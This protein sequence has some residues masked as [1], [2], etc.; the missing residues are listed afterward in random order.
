MLSP[1]LFALLTSSALISDV[2]AAPSKARAWTSWTKNAGPSAVYLTTNLQQN[3]VIALPVAE[4][5]TLSAGTVTS[6]GGAG[7]TAING[8]S[9]QLQAPDALLSQSAL[10][11]A[12]NVSGLSV[13]MILP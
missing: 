2:S 11:I 6:T 12:G 10:T 4:D 9:G 7:S 1:V 5:G 13:Q 8:A 3:A